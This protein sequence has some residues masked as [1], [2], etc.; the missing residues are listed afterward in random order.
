M[1]GIPTLSDENINPGTDHDQ[2]PRSYPGFNLLSFLEN[3][4]EER[5]ENLNFPEAR[6]SLY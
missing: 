3:P 6:H 4:R 2:L 5:R 1:C